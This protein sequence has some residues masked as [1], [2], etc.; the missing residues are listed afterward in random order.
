MIPQRGFA[1][2]SLGALL[3]Y[4][5]CATVNPR[6]DYER[7]ATYVSEATGQAGSYRP[8][9]DEIVERK[10]A[11]LLADGLTAAE[12]VQVCLLNNPRLQA[13][14]FDVGMARADLV[15]SG[16]LSNPSLGVSL[17][18]PSG[19]GLANLEG[20]FAQN[21]VD[22]WQIP[23]RKRAS[24][25]A[26][27]R[28]ILELAREASVLANTAKT[29]YY[30]AVGADRA[31]A[32]TTENLEIIQR[33]L[34]LAL[35]R[36]QAGVG[37]EVDV[38]LSLSELKEAELVRRSVRLVAFEARSVLAT[39]LG[40]TSSPGELD[41]RDPLP[42]PPEW[43]LS[44]ETL[45]TIAQAKRLDIQSA[46]QALEVAAANAKLERLRAF[47]VV[48]LGLEFERGERKRSPG[49]KLLARTLASSAEAGVF[50]LPRIGSNDDAGTDFI[51]GPSIGLELPIFDQ[52]QAQ[53]AIADYAYY[54]TVKLLDALIREVTQETRMAY[55]RAT[56]ARDTARFYRDDLLP[57]RETSLELA[58]DAY[59]AGSESFLVVL[60]AQ[61]TLL[62][63][64][65]GY[66]AALESW[67]VALVELERVTGQ[68]IERI[69]APFETHEDQPMGVDDPP[70]T[71]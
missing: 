16:L 62:A 57:L 70:S 46:R 61:R 40:L 11:E 34:D 3:A 13:A 28:A 69:L 50:S 32:V 48:E 24:A 20:S 43:A 65:A 30:Q 21:I 41:L 71:G 66:V 19:G 29:A 5:G 10:V 51:I 23:V 15:Q 27:D 14:F 4:G 39:L 12:A 55:E 6:P 47:P 35:V 18:L 64:R 22:L 54:Q 53:I 36:Q 63:T 56:T 2:L 9:E 17:R 33:L 38:N 26:L 68:P 31:L 45:L 25:R 49:G 7:V 67:A 37:T 60:E 44:A 52:N 1:V 59:R 58:H 42:D 8:G